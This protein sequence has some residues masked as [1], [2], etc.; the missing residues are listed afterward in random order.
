MHQIKGNSYDHNLADSRTKISA[1]HWRKQYLFH[2]TVNVALD[3]SYVQYV[4][5]FIPWSKQSEGFVITC[6]APVSF[7]I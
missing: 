1:T 6:P 4:D 2:L 7:R 5:V 3:L